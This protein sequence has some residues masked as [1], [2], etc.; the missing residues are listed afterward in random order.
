MNI[1]TMKAILVDTDFDSDVTCKGL[2]CPL[3]KGEG[4]RLVSVRIPLVSAS[5]SALASA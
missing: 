4:D 3:T 5:V 1:I 2:L